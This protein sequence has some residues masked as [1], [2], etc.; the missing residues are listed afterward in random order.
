MKYV[1]NR[2]KNSAVGEIADRTARE[3]FCAKNDI[4]TISRNLHVR[5][6][7]ILEAT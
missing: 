2:N 3:I 4:K 7:S 6:V 5:H 1:E